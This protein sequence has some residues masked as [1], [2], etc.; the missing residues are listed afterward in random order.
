MVPW[1]GLHAQMGTEYAEIRQ[2]RA[3]V[4][5]TLKE[6]RLVYPALKVEGTP[7]GLVISPSS[8][9]I[10]PTKIRPQVPRNRVVRSLDIHKKP[11]E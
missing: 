3:K 11:V 6:I 8:T 4:L 5:A 10:A 7:D 9:A 2:F 1:E